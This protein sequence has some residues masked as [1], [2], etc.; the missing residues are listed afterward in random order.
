M[1][2]T[3]SIK[4]ETKTKESFESEAE[5]VAKSDLGKQMAS[6]HSEKETYTCEICKYNS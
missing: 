2:E 5:F 6:I 4:T 1:I 3:K